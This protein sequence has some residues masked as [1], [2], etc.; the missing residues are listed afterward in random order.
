MRKTILVALIVLTAPWTA[1]ADDPTPGY[2]LIYGNR[3]GS[4]IDVN[5]NSD[6]EI[7]VWAATPAIGSGYEDLD[8]DGV[9]DS[10][11]FMHTPLA[12]NDSFIV[13]RDGGMVFYPLTTW[14]DVAF[15]T[16]N[17][18]PTPGYTN[19]SILGFG[20]DLDVLLITEGDT[21]LIA[22][23]YM[24]TTSDSSVLYQLSPTLKE[25]YESTN[26]NLVWAFQDWITPIRPAQTFSPLFF[27][28]YLAGDANRSGDVNGLDVVYL[29]NYLKGLGLPPEPIFA[30]DANGDC[31]ANGLDV[32]YLVTYLKGGPE[33]FLGSCH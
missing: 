25:G 16:P 12:S 29:V 31:L 9:I 5:L 3:D 17:P 24:H 15:L 14:R 21:M 7:K 20:E 28:D 23:F 2:Y 19:Q 11:L 26:G 10:I 22:T 32:I 30:G 13:S 18:D 8:G 1:Y 33:P 27:V 4:T 6:I